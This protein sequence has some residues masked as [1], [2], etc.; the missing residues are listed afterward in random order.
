MSIVCSWNQHVQNAMCNGESL[1]MPFLVKWCGSSM[2]AALYFRSLYKYNTQKG[3]ERWAM[4]LY[5]NYS[6]LLI[7]LISFWRK[8]SERPQG[9]AFDNCHLLSYFHVWFMLWDQRIPCQI[10]VTRIIVMCKA[11]GKDI[12]WSPCG[13]NY[14][15]SGNLCNKSLPFAVT[16]C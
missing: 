3:S 16:S 8:T 11:G 12:V 1:G 2:I 6:F 14:N 7:C 4:Q 15:L 13:T 9:V 10:E 5:Q